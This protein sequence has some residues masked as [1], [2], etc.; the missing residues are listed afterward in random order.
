MS[1]IKGRGIAFSNE[2]YRCTFDNMVI[3]ASNGGSYGI[4]FAGRNHVISNT[5]IY[6]FNKDI[7]AGGTD[8][9]LYSVITT[10]GVLANDVG[11]DTTTLKYN[12]SDINSIIPVLNNGF[13]LLA[14]TNCD[15]KFWK[16]GDT[17]HIEGEIVGTTL[18]TPIFTLPIGYR[19][20]KNIRPVIRTNNGV[21]GVYI[22]ATTGNVQ[23]EFGSGFAWFSLDGISFRI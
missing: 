15:A 6:G 11:G 14:P 4:Q 16:S 22:E 5:E 3:G 23:L 9:K 21:A 12:D 2:S 17:V 18:S 10:S 13:T 8:N 1:D 20:P 19:P 7:Q